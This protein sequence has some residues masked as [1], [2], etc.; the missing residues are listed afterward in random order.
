M[1]RSTKVDEWI[2]WQRPSCRPLSFSGPVFRPLSQLFLLSGGG[3]APAVFLFFIFSWTKW[4]LPHQN[5]F[6]PSLVASTTGI[7]PAS[8]HMLHFNLVFAKL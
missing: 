1:H 3:G 5:H 4:W 7:E 6:R 2:L 8:V